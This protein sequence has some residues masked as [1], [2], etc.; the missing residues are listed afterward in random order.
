[1]GGQSF[2][3]LNPPAAV[4]NPT[5]IPA[6]EFPRHVHKFAGLN[7]DGSAKLNTFK[8]VGSAAELETAVADGWSLTPVLEDPKSKAKK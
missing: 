2:D 6:A 7:D 8:V 3:H 4:H 5:G 1:M